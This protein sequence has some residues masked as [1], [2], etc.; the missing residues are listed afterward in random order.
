LDWSIEAQQLFK[1]SFGFASADATLADAKQIMD[2][3][4]KCGDVFVTQ[5]GKPTEPIVGWV[6]DNLIIE[7]ATV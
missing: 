1:S 4:P 3:I 7:N 5:T 6:T 2:K